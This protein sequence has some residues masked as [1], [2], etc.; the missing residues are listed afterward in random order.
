LIVGTL[1]FLYIFNNNY[2]QNLFHFDLT[3]IESQ[4][5]IAAIESPSPAKMQELLGEALSAKNT[6]QISTI[7]FWLTCLVL[8]V[9]AY[10]KNLSL[11][12]LMGL[13]TCLYLLTGMSLSNWKWF[14]AWFGIGLL[15][16]F[17]YGYRKSKLAN[18]A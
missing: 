3:E 14:F 13:T 11:I 16:Y 12:P 17:F 8:S 18:E 5:A 15:I 6:L 9:L 10:M 4:G 7:I 2:F 1:I